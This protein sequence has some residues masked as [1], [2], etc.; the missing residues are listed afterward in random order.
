[1]NEIGLRLHVLRPNKQF[2]DAVEDVN[3]AICYT[4]IRINYIN[5]F[6]ERL[7]AY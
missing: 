5:L 2:M 3:K 1:M 4:I 7:S 6:Y